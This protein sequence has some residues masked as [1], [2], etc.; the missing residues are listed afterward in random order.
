MKKYTIPA[1]LVFVLFIML[2]N[3]Y[4]TSA[5]TGN[6]SL[7]SKV[8]WE[9]KQYFFVF[10]DA[11]PDRPKI[12]SAKAMEIQMGHLGNIQKMFNEGKCR[13]AGPF[14]DDG[15]TRGIL[16]MDAASEDEVKELLKNDPAITNGRLNA[17]IRPW[18]GPA[19][20]Y[21]EP[22]ARK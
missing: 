1:L 14:L 8:E 21:A 20:L 11:V 7:N 4:S 13:L 2:L 17:V 3:V 19:G 22:K 18:Y 5:Q 16:I 9:M 10:L 6:D 12:D 15:N